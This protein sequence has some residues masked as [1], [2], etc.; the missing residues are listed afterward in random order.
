MNVSGRSQQQDDGDG[1]N[2]ACSSSS[3]CVICKVTVLPRLLLWILLCAYVTCVP[4]C[5]LKPNF[6]QSTVTQ[7]L[8]P[9]PPTPAENGIIKSDKVYEVMLATDRAHFSRCNPYMDSPQSIGVCV[10][11]P[12]PALSRFQSRP[13]ANLCVSLNPQAFK[14]P[15]VLHTW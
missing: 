10:H 14:Q 12:S 8:L 7:A 9:P 1:G 13:S 4:R 15:S 5:C 2:T 3:C 6:P 11:V